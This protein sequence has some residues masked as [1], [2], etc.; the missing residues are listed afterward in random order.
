[1]E[2]CEVIV[3]QCIGLNHREYSVS[4]PVGIDGVGVTWPPPS[5]MLLSVLL[6]DTR[7]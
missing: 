4:V 5:S 6:L 7:R 2:D 3:D 1:M